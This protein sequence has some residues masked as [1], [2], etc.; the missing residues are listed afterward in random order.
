MIGYIPI[1]TKGEDNR[2]NLKIEHIERAPVKYSE[3]C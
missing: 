2:L 1:K 3:A